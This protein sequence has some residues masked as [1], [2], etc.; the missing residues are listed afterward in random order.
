MKVSLEKTISKYIDFTAEEFKSIRDC[1]KIKTLKRREILHDINTVCKYV[2]F[3]E[4]GIIR[5]FQVEDGEEVT[6]QFFFTGGWYTD[7]ESFL[8]NSYSRQ[9]AQAIES[10]SLLYISK[11]DLEKLYKEIPQFERFGRLMAEQAFIGLRKKTDN[12]TLL[13][14]KERY[15]ML[16]RQR[17]KV[18]EKIPQHYIASYLGIKPQSLS[19]IRKNLVL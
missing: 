7:L 4:E 13:D 6:G 2:Y 14:A 19:R 12:L 16:L 5:Y 17:P 3:I 1:F 18:I 9:T 10:T 15:L 8:S 11:Q